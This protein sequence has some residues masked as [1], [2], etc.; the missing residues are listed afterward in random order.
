MYHNTVDKPR[1]HVISNS[2]LVGLVD[3]MQI[4]LTVGGLVCRIKKSVA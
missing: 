2:I 3:F 1:V 4:G